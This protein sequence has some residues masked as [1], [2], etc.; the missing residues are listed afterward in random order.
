[1]WL[2]WLCV[3]WNIRLVDMIMWFRHVARTSALFRTTTLV[4]TADDVKTQN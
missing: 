2:L 4:M 3:F 1:M